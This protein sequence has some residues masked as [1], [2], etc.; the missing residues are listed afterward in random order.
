MRKKLLKVT[1]IIVI[2]SI[3]ILMFGLGSS[4]IG[5]CRLIYNQYLDTEFATGF[6]F[7]NFNEIQTGMHKKQVI[8]TYRRTFIY[9][10]G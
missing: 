8:E 2:P 1:S 3:L 5:E 6:S 9:K 10:N 4:L 7:K